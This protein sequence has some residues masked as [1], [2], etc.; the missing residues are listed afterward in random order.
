MLPPVTAI[1][2][3]RG[4]QWPAFDGLRAIAVLAV[5]VFH[6]N[7]PSFIH[8]GYVGVDVFF[9]LSGFLI[10]WLLTTEH[11]SLQGIAYGKFYARRALRLFPALAALIVVSILL[12]TIDGGLVVYRHETLV[13]L[14]WVLFYLGN[15]PIAWGNS[16]TLGLLAVTWTLAIE[17]QYYLLWPLGLNKLLARVDRRRIA[18]G[19]M[20]AAVLEELVRF[21]MGLSNDLAVNLWADKATVTHSDGLLVGSALAL[22]WTTRATWKLWPIIERRAN[23]LGLVGAALVGASIL[24]GTPNLHTTYVWVTVAVYGT[25]L[26]VTSLVARPT[27][28]ISLILALAPLQWI[29]RRSYGMYIWHFPIIVVVLNLNLPATHLHFTR[30]AIE[31]VA[32]FVVTA[33]SYQ[34]IEQPFLRRKIR[35]SRIPEETSTP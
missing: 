7:Y 20:I 13:G 9:V 18:A 11:D 4:R 19:L 29:G 3:E 1:P 16:L 14:P 30:F 15:W 27:S 22:M 32:I 31:I 24:L 8:G 2:T 28:W 12:V 33:L 6:A 5:V 34:V 21:V 23:E 35:F 10:T 17:E 25:L 26:L